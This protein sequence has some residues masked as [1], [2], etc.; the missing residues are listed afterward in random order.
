MSSEKLKESFAFYAAYHRNPVN[1]ILHIITIPLISWSILVFLD[2]L[3]TYKL[4]GETFALTF[5]LIPVVFYIGI[6][7]LLE[8]RIGLLMVPYILSEYL[9]ASIYRFNVPYAWI[10]AGII[11]VFAWIL[12]FMGHGIW[13]GRKP[14]LLDSLTQAFVM[15]PLFVFMEMLFMCGWRKAFQ[16]EIEDLSRAYDPIV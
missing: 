5:A 16:R 7:I 12:Q 10:S 2:Y 13:E 3:P 8:W 11:F 6:Y 1:K 9:L 14:A 4:F 15:A